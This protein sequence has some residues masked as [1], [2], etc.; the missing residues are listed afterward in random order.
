VH[1]LAF[2]TYNAQGAAGVIKDGLTS[3]KEVIKAFTEAGGGRLVGMWGVESAEVDFVILIESDN[4]PP[5]QGAATGLGQRS[6]GHLAELHTYTLIET[7]DV[8]AAVRARNPVTRPPG[9]D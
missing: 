7:E 5:A 6:M 1:Y 2:G 9:V 8:D 4:N 3:R